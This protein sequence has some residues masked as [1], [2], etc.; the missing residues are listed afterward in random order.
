MLV[1]TRKENESI[2]IGNDGVTVTI[3]EVRGGR[4]R[5]GISADPHIPIRR[6]ELSFDRESTPVVTSRA[7]A[8]WSI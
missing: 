4:V 8:E 1:L 6:K 2:E 5:I 3:L 7:N